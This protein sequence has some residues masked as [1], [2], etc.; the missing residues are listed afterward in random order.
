[1]G[2]SASAPSP[3]LLEARARLTQAQLQALDAC[4]EAA[5][6]LDLHAF[7]ARTALRR[8]CASA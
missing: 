5:D 8:R 7:Q 2:A 6:E 4:F 1:M 3:A